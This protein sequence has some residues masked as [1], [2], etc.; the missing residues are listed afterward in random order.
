MGRKNPAVVPYA[1]LA[2]SEDQE[3][4]ARWEMKWSV[5]STEGEGLLQSWGWEVPPASQVP[6]CRMKFLLHSEPPPFLAQSWPWDYKR[7]G[8]GCAARGGEGKEEGWDPQGGCKPLSKTL[9]ASS[10]LQCC[11]SGPDPPRPFS[12]PS[13]SLLELFPWDARQF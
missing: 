12:L 4:W 6:F 9:F 7:V 1:S 10:L 13:P 2:R 3:R 11:C 8:I 5:H